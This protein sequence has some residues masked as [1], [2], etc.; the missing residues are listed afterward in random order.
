[1][2]TKKLNKKLTLSK[3]TITHLGKEEL[4]VVKGGQ[5]SFGLVVCVSLVCYTPAA[6]CP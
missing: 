1:M 5:P 3:K 2:K 4:N 6:T